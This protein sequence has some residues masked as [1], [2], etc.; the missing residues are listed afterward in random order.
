[1]A[2]TSL[3]H[4]RA[5]HAAYMTPAPCAQANQP[6]IGDPLPHFQIYHWSKNPATMPISLPALQCEVYVSQLVF[7]V[8]TEDIQ[9]V[10]N[11]LQTC[12]IRVCRSCIRETS[13]LFTSPTTFHVVSQA[14]PCFT[15]LLPLLAIIGDITL[16]P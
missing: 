4:F 9:R 5:A 11:P 3:P 2:S 8:L 14:F 7:D 12:Y 1:M 15:L 16:F 6:D 13:R 10:R